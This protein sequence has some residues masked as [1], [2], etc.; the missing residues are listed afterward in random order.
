MVDPDS[1]RRSFHTTRWSL[2]LATGGDDEERTRALEELCGIYWTPVYAFFRRRGEGEESARDLTQG[3]FA[4]L[5]AKGDFAK[6][7]PVRGRFR[8]YLKTCARHFA[9]NQHEADTAEKRG[10]GAPTVSLDPFAGDEE[11]D[12]EPTD[13]LTP[14]QAFERQFAQALLSVVLD[15]LAEEFGARGRRAQFDGLRCYL[16]VDGGPGFA[17]SAAALGMSEGAVKV[18]VHRM[19]ER[20]RELLVAEVRQ[21]LADPEDA[22]DEVDQLLAALR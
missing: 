20:F 15:R 21:T 4:Q 22:A 5:I 8:A 3:L 7:D 17:T 1:R 9:I 12:I 10:G 2:V 14:E 11:W 13:T 18:T 16:E 19:R 6:A